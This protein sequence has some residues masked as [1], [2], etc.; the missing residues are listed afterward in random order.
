MAKLTKSQLKGIVK[1]CLVEIL[2]EG[3]SSSLSPSHLIEASSQPKKRRSPKT[4]KRNPQRTLHK[5]L[6]SV[7]YNQQDTENERFEESVNNTVQNLTSDPIMA[8]IFTDTA[9]TTLQE[10]ASADSAGQGRPSQMESVAPGK[11]LSEIDIF[12]GASQNWAALAF[13]DKPGTK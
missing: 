6:D 3:L 4:S 5:A 8:S 10:M 11:D 1:E 7:V 9:R 12:S 13:A 2:E